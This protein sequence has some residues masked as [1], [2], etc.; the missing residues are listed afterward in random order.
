MMQILIIIV[1]HNVD[2]GNTEIQG[3]AEK[4]AIIK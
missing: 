4:R 2:S 3:A 1:A